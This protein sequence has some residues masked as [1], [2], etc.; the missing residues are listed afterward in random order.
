MSKLPD[1][2]LTITPAGDDRSAF[3]MACPHCGHTYVEDRYHGADLSREVIDRAYIRYGSPI[4]VCASCGKEFLDRSMREPALQ[5]APVKSQLTKYRR[6]G[7]IMILVGVVIA[8]ACLLLSFEADGLIGIIGLGLIVAGLI[9]VL[10]S[11]QGLKTDKELRA[12]AEASRQRV[13]DP[14]YLDRLRENGII[15]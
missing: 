9:R 5:D 8:V 12:E 7:A 15:Q 6:S 4:R 14:A 3:T 11:P 1:Y 13:A 10:A 2:T